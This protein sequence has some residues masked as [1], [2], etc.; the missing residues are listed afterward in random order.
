MTTNDKG[1]FKRQLSIELSTD[2]GKDVPV[3]MKRILFCFGFLGVELDKFARVN[4]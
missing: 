4:V 1:A 3:Y 2:G